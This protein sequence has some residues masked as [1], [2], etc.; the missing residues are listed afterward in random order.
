MEKC[1]AGVTLHWLWLVM[2]DHRRLCQ[3]S[4][5]AQPGLSGESAAEYLHA[6]SGLQS[7]DVE[8]VIILRLLKASLIQTFYTK[9]IEKYTVD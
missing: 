1:G 2:M 8:S 6:S 7:V 3:P 9:T 5:A 4:R